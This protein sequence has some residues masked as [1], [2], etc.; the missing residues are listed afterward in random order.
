MRVG[1]REKVGKQRRESTSKGATQRKD[2]PWSPHP[3]VD[4]AVE[5][6][7]ARV[8]VRVLH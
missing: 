7:L 8:S 6:V 3:L 5:T 1:K 2:V 4:H